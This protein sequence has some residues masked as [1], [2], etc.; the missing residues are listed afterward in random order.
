MSDMMVGTDVMLPTKPVKNFT[1]QELNNYF[2]GGWSFEET[3]FILNSSNSIPSQINVAPGVP[4]IEV[5]PPAPPGKF[6]IIDP[7]YATWQTIHE[8]GNPL[9]S[10]AAVP[11][12]FI[13]Q[14]WDFNY[15]IL[16]STSLLS[17]DNGAGLSTLTQMGIGTDGINPEASVNTITKLQKSPVYGLD[18][19]PVYVSNSGVRILVVGFSDLNFVGQATVKLQVRY[20][21]VNL[22]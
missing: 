12:M 16:A 13:G 15:N 9:V 2:F 4:L 22:I 1:I 3:T 11:G 18:E 20:K 10:T 7:K 6:A 14:Y 19:Y 5:V 8:P 21:Y 17:G